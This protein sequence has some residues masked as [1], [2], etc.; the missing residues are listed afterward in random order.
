MNQV[1]QDYFP[2]NETTEDTVFPSGCFRFAI[3]ELEDGMSSTDKRMFGASFVC[4]EP[5]EFAGM[6]FRENYVVGTPE[7]PNGINSGTPGNKAMKKMLARAQ[8]PP[9]NS[10]QA[11]LM[12][13]RGAELLI[14]INKYKETKEGQY[15]GQDR[16]RA[17]DYVRVGERLVGVVK[18]GAP[19]QVIPSAPTMPV[20]PPPP[21]Y[22]PPPAM[23]TS[24]APS[25]PPSWPATPQPAPYVPPVTPASIP[26]P[27][28]PTPVGA[29]TA[30]IG[31][32]L[33]CTICQQDVSVGDFGPHIQAHASGR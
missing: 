16:N 13:A 8:V 2:W 17:S 9:S 21:T 14:V 19:G 20:S 4:K 23:P 31:P 12:A 7:N 30:P 33:R 1:N 28:A 15:K 32:M 26:V 6:Y 5:S 22:S 11:L 27:S 25:A 18:E 3:H 10:V 24:V 29:A